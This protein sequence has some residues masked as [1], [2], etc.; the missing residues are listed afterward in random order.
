MS[1]GRSNPEIVGEGAQA[2]LRLTLDVYT[3]PA[4]L[5]DVENGCEERRKEEDKDNE[6]TG[7]GKTPEQLCILVY[8]WGEKPRPSGFVNDR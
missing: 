8:F 1:S 5:C 2:L 4:A 3:T 7:K 6:G